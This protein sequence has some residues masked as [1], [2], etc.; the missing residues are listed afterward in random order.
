MAVIAGMFLPAALFVAL[1]FSWLFPGTFWLVVL[2]DGIGLGV[3]Y[4]YYAVWEN[5][6]I[7]FCCPKCTK[8]ISSNTPWVCAECG[9]PNRNANDYPFVFECQHCGAEAKAYK[10]HHREKKKDC[11]EIIF[12]S[13]DRDATNYAHRLDSPS[14]VPAPDKHA[15]NMTKLE[16]RKQEKL[17]RRDLELVNE[18]LTSIRKRIRAEK[19]KKKTVKEN[20]EEGVNS[21]MELESA[22]AELEAK[23]AKEYEGNQPLLKRMRAA[24]KANVARQKSEGM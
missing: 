18:Q 22:E 1:L 2:I 23:F 11:G 17:A 13:E 12:L 16:K 21:D 4:Y 8:I 24:L 10:C 6:P 20:L 15:E 14:E 19:Q 3:A 5:Q 7:R 9:E